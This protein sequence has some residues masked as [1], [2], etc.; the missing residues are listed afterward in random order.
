MLKLEIQTVESRRVFFIIL[1]QRCI[2]SANAQYF[3]GAFRP[4]QERH[5][6]AWA[7]M[8]RYAIN[9]MHK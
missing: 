3:V 4:F 6:I 7:K 9:H 1:F 5:V 8:F 2:F